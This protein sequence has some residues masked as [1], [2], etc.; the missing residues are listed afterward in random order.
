MLIVSLASWSSWGEWSN[1]TGPCNTFGTR[2]RVRVC[3]SEI[4][5]TL[6]NTICSELHQENQTT[7]YQE[8]MTTECGE[9]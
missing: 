7:E 1:C 2:N 8:C 5:G 6:E 3:A 9:M 4:D